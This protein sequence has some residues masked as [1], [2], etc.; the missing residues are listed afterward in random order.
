[1]SEEN[2]FKEAREHAKAARSETRAAV[3]SLLPDSFWQHADESK[4][5]AKLAAEA[6]RR[7][8][9]QQ[10]CRPVRPSAPAKHKIDIA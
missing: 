3:R 10:F 7:A 6:F 1:M 8:F 9:R 2:T 4:R 5:E